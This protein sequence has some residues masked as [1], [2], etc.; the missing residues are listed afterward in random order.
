MQSIQ[1]LLLTGLQAVLPRND[2]TAALKAVHTV[3]WATAT[4]LMSVMK[5]PLK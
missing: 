2:F 1:D 5:A 4:A 3:V